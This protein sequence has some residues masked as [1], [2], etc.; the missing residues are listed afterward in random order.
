MNA[1]KFW[2][3]AIE[4]VIRYV[5]ESRE[6][7]IALVKKAIA[8]PSENPPG[9]EAG[10]AALLSGVLKVLGFNPEIVGE[11][12]RKSVICRIKGGHPGPTLAYN[13]HIDTKPV[14]DL[15]S[16]RTDPFEAVE[17]D[18]RIYGLGAAD[19]KAAVCA[20]AYAAATLRSLFEDLCG[21]LL[22]VFNA[23]EEAGGAFGAAKIVERS[24]VMA[25]AMVIGEPS[26][27]D[28]EWST[29]NIGSRGVCNFKV[30]V[31]GTQVHTGLADPKTSINA[32]VKMANVLS[33]MGTELKIRYQP[34]PMFEQG[35]SVT[36]G[37]LV[38]S[39]VYYGI[40]PGY[41]EFSSDIRTVP[42][43]TPASVEEDVNAF[44]DVLRREDP[45]LR[46]EYEI[47]QQPLGWKDAVYTDPSDRAVLC[48]LE[49]AKR[50]LSVEPRLGIFQAWTDATWYQGVA[51]IP[52]IPAFGPGLGQECHKPN[53][54]V[55]LE[56]VV[57]AAK[58]YAIAALKFLAPKQRGVGSSAS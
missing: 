26:S 23:D 53:E 55:K 9:N 8:T 24:L 31:Y 34:V 30:K 14:G 19:M 25:D 39:G 52:C 4:V 48:L 56:A 44:L 27:F 58:I 10:M 21:D 16:W 18:G 6:D 29:L 11:G 40:M 33:R 12:N 5:D 51:G 57:E 7:L 54:S 46:V 22:L 28:H 50:V 1:A 38:K 36:P 15:A 2:E 45:Q 32:S 49:A 17:K 43:M 13:G 42:G 47:E 41:A 3:Q 35:P 20:M 37:V